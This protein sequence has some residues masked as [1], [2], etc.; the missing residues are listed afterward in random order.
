M[1]GRKL[2]AQVIEAEQERKFI[3]DILPGQK[4]THRQCFLN[5]PDYMNY[6]GVL[7]NNTDIQISLLKILIR[8]GGPAICLTSNSDFS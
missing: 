6:L 4:S 5:L 7:A 1:E 8:Y 3:Y 2:E